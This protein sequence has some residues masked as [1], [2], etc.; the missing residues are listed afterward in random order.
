[1]AEV[2]HRE[3]LRYFE[4]P[5]TTARLVGAEFEMA[6]YDRR[7]AEPLRYGGERGL[8]VVLE[9]IADLGWA[10]VHED[11]HIIALSNEQGA[12]SIEP[13]GQLEL[14][15]P[16]RGDTLQ[17]R[18]DARGFA[19]LLLEVSDGLDIAWVAVGLNPLSRTQD[20]EVVPKKR[21]AVMTEYLSKKGSMALDMMRRTQSVHVTFDYRDEQEIAE[22]AQAANLASP[23]LA[24]VFSHSPL[25]EGKEVGVLSQRTFIWRETDA[26]RCGLDRD[27]IEGRWT[28]E[29]YLNRLLDIP[30]I[31]LIKDGEFHPAHGIPAREY[32]S[33]RVSDT[34]PC[35]DDLEWVINQTF[36][37]V[38]I[39]HYIES[40]GADM[41]P[42]D[43]A[44]AIAAAWS[45]LLYDE[46]AREGAIEV[47]S[48]YSYEQVLE[49]QLEVARKGLCAVAPDGRKICDLAESLMTFAARALSMRG[50]GEE[51]LLDPILERIESCQTPADDLLEVWNG[52]AQRDPLKLIDFLSLK[53][54][55]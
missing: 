4:K 31:F 21:Y 40:R 52:P 18:D 6:G 43:F 33:G 17:I 24:G 10:P 51:T 19:E 8:E 47:L 25:S 13:G 45:G 16:P 37:D 48:D 22:M 54:S 30:L 49:L 36:P 35:P 15:T 23:I 11:G 50:L 53:P 41:P 20:I 38:R 55:S 44:P 28:Y 9:R 7:T 1:M 29:R 5:P 3:L 26:D 32:F 46:S 39:R 27:A 42:L 14:S 12:L 2:N 34:R